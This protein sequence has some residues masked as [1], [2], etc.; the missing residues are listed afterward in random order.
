MTPTRRERRKHSR[1][2]ARG[3]AAV[4]VSAATIAGMVVG[5]PAAHAQAPLK[6]TTVAGGLTIPWG[7]VVA[8][9]GTVLTGERAGRFVA[10][11]PGGTRVNVT[12]DLSNI[13]AFHEAGLMGLAIDPRFSEN[14]RVY[15]CQA[16][17]TVPGAFTVPEPLAGAPIP[18]PQTG[19]TTKVVSWRVSADWTKMARERTI[20]GNIPVNSSGSRAGCGLAVT[21]DSIWVGTGDTGTPSFAQA[22]KSLGGKVLHITRDGTPA[23]GNPDPRSPVYSLGHRN[24]QGVA[25]APGSGRVYA[26]EQGTTRDDE[27]NLIVAGGNYGYKPDRT[28]LIYDE[29]VP[30]TDTGRVPGAIGPVWSSG[31]STIATPG[32]AFLPATGWGPYSGG[33]VLTAL[34][35]KRLVFLKL[36]D[37]GR[38]VV[39]KTEALEQKHGRLR[40]AAVAPDGSLV[41]TTSD[42]DGSDRILRVRWED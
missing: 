33:L 2:P 5:A 4:M 41:L 14:R 1:S 22:R 8:P 23:P 30:M 36:S 17:Y 6:V 10:V 18:A 7:V 39:S 11:R 24:V 29:S 31:D 42:G 15:S 26:V 27:L 16:E 35:G 13:F 12:A 20:L 38:R 34:K 19:Q 40:G 28:P 9:D 25:V 37:D 32:I 3:L 21:P